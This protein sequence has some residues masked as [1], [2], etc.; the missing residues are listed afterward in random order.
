MLIFVL[1]LKR[2]YSSFILD[3]FS[4]FLETKANKKEPKPPQ[5]F[6]N[7]RVSF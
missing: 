7:A 3:I 2:A 1:Q 5:I 6:V 4:N